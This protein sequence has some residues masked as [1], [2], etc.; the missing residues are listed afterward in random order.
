M[1]VLI[2]PLLSINLFCTIVESERTT[3]LAIEITLT[4]RC[5]KNFVLSLLL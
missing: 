1:A 5:H 4:L 2:N 3:N